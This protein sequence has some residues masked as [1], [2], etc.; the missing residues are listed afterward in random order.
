MS[1]VSVR[2][3]VNVLFIS[4][5]ITWPTKLNL[6]RHLSCSNRFTAY[7]SY[8]IELKLGRM[9]L[10]I[11]LHNRWESDFP[12]FLRGVLLGR[13]FWNFEIDSQPAVFI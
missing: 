4:S 10:D 7:I 12:V 9:I 1:R 2:P 13:A 3:S 6:A 5:V 8:E 11:S